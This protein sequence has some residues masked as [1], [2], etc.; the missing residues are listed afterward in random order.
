MNDGLHICQAQY[1]NNNVITFMFDLESLY[2]HFL[3]EMVIRLFDRI[4]I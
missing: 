4:C 1:N 3:H 2:F